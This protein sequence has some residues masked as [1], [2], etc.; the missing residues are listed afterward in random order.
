[1]ANCSDSDYGLVASSFEATSADAIGDFVDKFTCGGNL[2]P[3][4]ITALKDELKLVHQRKAA[5]EQT[6]QYSS[7]LALLDAVEAMEGGQVQVLGEVADLDEALKKVGMTA[8]EFEDVKAFKASSGHYEEVINHLK[9]STGLAADPVEGVSE[10]ILRNFQRQYL[11]VA[12]PLVKELAEVHGSLD[13]VQPGFDYLDDFRRET[14]I[15]VD[16]LYEST[17]L[18]REGDELEPETVEQLRKFREF[19]KR[20]PTSELEPVVAAE[21]TYKQMVDHYSDELAEIV[22]ARRQK[23]LPQVIEKFNAIQKLQVSKL[24]VLGLDLSA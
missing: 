12:E 3:E 18:R 24:G 15:D 2:T 6:V 23:S 7:K 8:Q 22:A 14:G 10:K 19:M 5:L 13:Q 11:S 17:M 4:A 1:M 21:S 20:P 16:R 9:A